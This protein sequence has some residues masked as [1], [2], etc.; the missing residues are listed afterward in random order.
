MNVEDRMHSVETELARQGTRLGHLETGM[1]KAVDGVEKRLERD[2]RRPSPM[3]LPTV[4][5]TLVAAAGTMGAIGA[6]VWWIVAT[7]PAVQALDQRLTR[8]DDPE[9]G[10]VTTLANSILP[11]SPRAAK[12]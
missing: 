8:L 2:A 6:F 11:W 10:R 3:N 12:K 5:T 1:L 9:T 4:L 7:S